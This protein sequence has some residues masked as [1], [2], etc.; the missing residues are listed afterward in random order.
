MSK[1]NIAVVY[2]GDS[3]EIVVSQNSAKGVMSFIDAVKYNAIPVLITRKKWVARIDGQDYPICKDDFSCTVKD[4]KINFDCAYVT[5]H[6]TPGEDGKLQ[7]YFD[8]IGMPY[9]TCG[10]LPA[11]LTFNKFACNSY[12][13]GF[14]LK[15]AD[16][17]LVL[18]GNDFD[19]EQIIE[20][21]GLPCFVK[22][23]AGGS[24][25]G[26]SKAKTIADVAPAI[27]KAFAE[28]DEV[29]IEQFVQGNEFTCGLYKTNKGETIFPITEVIPANEFFDFEAK[30]TPEKV[31]EITPA[32]LPG[33]T[34]D[35]IRKVTSLV[36]DILGCKGIVRV[37][38]ILS[39]N[40]IFLLEVNTVPGM[41]PTSFIPQQ[42]A[43][44]GLDIK[45]VFTDVIES[46]LGVVASD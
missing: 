40:N 15:V 41:T 18:K 42:I 11:S 17:V 33:E 16:S 9:T 46:S 25:F 32:R 44:A 37:D 12:L 19:V 3:S 28:S 24:S 43:A 35:R 31:Q 8:I 39:G 29:I 14:G 1:K 38:Y 34:A 27:H 36:Y 10:V 5:I 6:G 4:K 7:G 45:A 13:K 30:Y 26:I 23:N 20:K 22:P 2:G 21:L